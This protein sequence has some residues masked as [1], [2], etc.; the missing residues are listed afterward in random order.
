MTSRGLKFLV[1]VLRQQF[2]EVDSGTVR[3]R[4]WARGHVR[5]RSRRAFRTS[6]E[7]LFLTVRLPQGVAV[8]LASAGW[9]MAMCRFR[10]A[11]FVGRTWSQPESS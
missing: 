1:S 7:E 4:P 3:W 11:R 10:V 8:K 5:V 6:W 9:R 2:A